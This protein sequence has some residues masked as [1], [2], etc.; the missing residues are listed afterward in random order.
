MGK[1]RADS[2]LHVQA[3]ALA[4]IVHVASQR[5][6]KM[7]SPG[8]SVQCGTLAVTD[9]TLS[10]SSE[11]GIIPCTAGA[12]VG[13]YYSMSDICTCTCTCMYILASFPGHFRLSRNG[14]GTTIDTFAFIP[15]KTW[16]IVYTFHSM[17]L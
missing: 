6:C 12:V 4:Y 2:N 16:D 15:I 8:L 1:W 13:A 9:C 10:I 7:G 5:S 11:V 3:L 17:P 14:L